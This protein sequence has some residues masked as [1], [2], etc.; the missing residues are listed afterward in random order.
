M[1]LFYYFNFEKSYDVLKSK[2]PWIFLNKN[3]GFNKNET[4]SKIPHKVLER[5]TLW[6]WCEDLMSWSSQNKG[7][8]IFCTVCFVQSDFFFQIFAFTQC[9]V[10]YIHFHNKLTFTF[11]KTLLHTLLLL[12]SKIV[13]SLQCILKQA[14]WCSKKKMLLKR[15]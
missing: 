13:E 11:Q 14:K 7:K 2:I 12:V 9:I 4:Q 1:C 10:H 3:I 6:L 5:Q 8:C 15:L